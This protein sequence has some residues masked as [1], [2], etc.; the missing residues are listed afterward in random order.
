MRK[1][2]TAIIEELKSTRSSQKMYLIIGTLFELNEDNKRVENEM[3]YL[4]N[5]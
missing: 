4:Q 2:F 3:F 5:F 1:T